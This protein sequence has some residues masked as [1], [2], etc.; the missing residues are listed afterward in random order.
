M[1]APN[2]WKGVTHQGVRQ[3]CGDARA[4]VLQLAQEGRSSIDA[5]PCECVID[6]RM[7]TRDLYGRGGEFTASMSTMVELT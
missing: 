1:G 6:R 3:V 2:G 7:P 4:D 5:M